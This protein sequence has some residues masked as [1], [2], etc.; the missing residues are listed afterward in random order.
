[1]VFI[2]SLKETD[3]KINKHFDLRFFLWISLANLVIFTGLDLLDKSINIEIYDMLKSLAISIMI[4]AVVTV[5]Y[6]RL[7]KKYPKH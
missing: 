5:V 3:V 2:N 7:L 1:V 6:S 4:G